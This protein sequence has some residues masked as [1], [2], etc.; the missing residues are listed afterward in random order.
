[1]GMF[2]SLNNRKMQNVI[3]KKIPQHFCLISYGIFYVLYIS[4][5]L[6]CFRYIINLC[7]YL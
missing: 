2:Y 6:L 3:Y 7:Q 5:R 1:M 4:L